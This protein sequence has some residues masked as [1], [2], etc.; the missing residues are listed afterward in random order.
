VGLERIT[1]SLGPGKPDVIAFHYAMS[2][3]EE[4][5]VDAVERGEMRVEELFQKYGSQ[6]HGEG[7]A[8]GVWPSAGFLAQFLAQC[9]SFVRGLSVLE[10]GGGV[11]VPGISAAL[12]GA[13]DV[14]VTDKHPAAVELVR[15]N[16][17]ANGVA[18]T[19]RAAQMDFTDSASWPQEQF[20]VI[21]GA[22]ILL[23]DNHL[24]EGRG[25]GLA[26]MCRKLLP[27][28]GRALI[29]DPRERMVRPMFWEHCEELGLEIAKMLETK[30]HI[31]LNVMQLAPS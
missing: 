10:V 5:A 4:S 24:K 2:R 22:D 6:L 12:S 30:D 25:E 14:L 15:K 23:F 13:R 29:V 1:F 17:E 7:V 20:D 19:V 16:A 11:G 31:L 18:A 27:V 21:I 26:D 3:D 9:P 8:V 28:S